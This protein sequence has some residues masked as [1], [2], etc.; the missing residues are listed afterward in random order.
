M[1]DPTKVGMV[2]LLTTFFLDLIELA[3]AKIASFVLTLRF[4]LYFIL[5][6]IVSAAACFLLKDA[7]S[8]WY[9][10]ALAGTF[11]G[12]GVLSNSDIKIAG[13]DLVP[14]ATLFRQI[15]AKMME[16]A[17]D[18]KAEELEDIQV[19]AALAGRLRL[20]PLSKLRGYC[21]DALQGA[22]WNVGKVEAELR[23]AAASDEESR[24]LI[25]LMLTNN[26]RFVKA[27]I[28]SWESLKTAI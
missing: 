14:L 26:P 2:I 8:Q 17:A 28:E 13:Q 11:L 15:K 18:E 1:N 3:F 12:V 5:H 4:V 20:L 7:I 16:Q 24:A 6:C 27:Q 22:K 9:L 23:K 21:G 19:R 10:L 25:E